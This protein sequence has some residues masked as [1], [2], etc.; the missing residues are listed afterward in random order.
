MAATRKHKPKKP[1]KQK[2]IG[3][4][5]TKVNPIAEAV[6]NRAVKE[7]QTAIKPVRLKRSTQTIAKNVVVDQVT[8][9]DLKEIIPEL[10]RVNNKT[11]DLINEYLS[12]GTYGT[13]FEQ[14]LMDYRHLFKNKEGVQLRTYVQNIQFMVL[15]M[16]GLSDVDAYARI[17]P[18][19]YKQIMT[20]S[21]NP[22]LD[23]RTK[24]GIF[25]NNPT[26]HLLQ[27]MVMVPTC[28]SHRHLFYDA[29]NVA[30]DIMKD[31]D[32]RAGSRV[33]AA[34]LVMQYTAIPDH[35]QRHMEE[36]SKTIDTEEA[37]DKKM[38]IIA[39]LVD[40]TNA[41]AQKQQEM[42]KNKTTNVKDIATGRI[43][44][45]NEDE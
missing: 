30:A 2:R 21:K 15:T 8:A 29:L 43:I 45:V 12:D 31:E 19:K 18:A 17:F 41:L 11:L 22:T 32:V 9:N 44:E 3:R 10:Q 26:M 6:E 36:Q 20:Y 34:A 28:I 38:D 4:K 33:D 5:Y 35:I 1:I 25:K 24:I 13:Q 39:Q 16:Q 40:A 42:I 14:M 27:Q 7:A 37:E 23:L